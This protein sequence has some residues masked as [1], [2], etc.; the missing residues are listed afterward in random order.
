M[1]A[2]TVN[3]KQLTI[4]NVEILGF[5]EVVKYTR[6]MWRWDGLVSGSV[7]QMSSIKLNDIALPYTFIAFG[8]G[9]GNDIAAQPAS[10]M[11]AAEE[12][13]DNKKWCV[14]NMY[15][16]KWGWIIFDMPTAIK[17]IKYQLQI[18]GDT[19]QN[20]GR[21]PTRTRLYAS[22]G[23]PTTFEDDSWELLVDSTA[24]LPTTNYAWT[25]VW[26]E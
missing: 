20:T 16:N 11:V 1:N 21:N 19:A 23:T 14:S 5:D 10:K 18:G 9:S 12:L 26:S 7:F 24:V 25:T 3:G 13:T 2:L 22:T 15:S 17:L 8:K 4:D 6:F